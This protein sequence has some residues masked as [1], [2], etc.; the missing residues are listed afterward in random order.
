MTAMTET[1]HLAPEVRALVLA[2]LAARVKGEQEPIK[3]EF[4]PRYEPGT[5]IKW[6][7]PLDGA[8]LGYVQRTRPEPRWEITDETALR[9]HLAAE[10]KG[11]VETVTYLAVP[12]V[13][14]VEMDPIDELA[15]VVAAHA[16]HLLSTEDR[17]SQEAVDAALAESKANGVAAAPGITRVRPG[18]ALRVVPDK[19]AGEA[20]ER[21]VRAGIV[22]WDGRPVLEQGA[23]REA[24]S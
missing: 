9:E 3:A 12:G 6:E 1:M 4:S 7:S 17:V 5:T 22:T 20:V 19:G 11:V 15:Q 14:L 10:F 2:V 16:P 24:A 18:G 13:G 8:L 23:E 21:L